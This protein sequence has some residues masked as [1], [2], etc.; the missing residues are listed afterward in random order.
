MNHWLGKWKKVFLCKMGEYSREVMDAGLSSM[1]LMY[2]D[3]CARKK[4]ACVIKC[5]NEKCIMPYLWIMY[6]VWLTDGW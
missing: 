6:K 4:T 3:V 5:W 2:H 1:R